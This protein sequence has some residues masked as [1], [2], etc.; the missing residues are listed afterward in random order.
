MK[1]HASCSFEK[2]LLEKGVEKY[3]D[4]FVF[5]IEVFLNYTYRYDHY[6]MVTLQS[7]TLECLEEFFYD[8]IL[9]KVMLEPN[10]YVQFPPAIK[11]FYRFLSEK[12]YLNNSDTIEIMID[13]IE[14]KLLI[15]LRKRFS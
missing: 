13:E 3:K 15:I 1:I 8:H 2:W 5:Y 7:M 11:L 14:P 12:E 4:E 9:R 10:E 6:D